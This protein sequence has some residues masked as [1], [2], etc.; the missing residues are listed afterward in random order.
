MIKAI[1][2]SLILMTS[3]TV[4]SADVVDRIVAIVNSEIILESDFRSLALKTKNPTMID[5][6]LLVKGDLGSLKS[7]RKAQ[8][9]YLINEKLMDAEVKRL[10]LT[11]TSERIQQEIKEMG[12]R[13]GLQA[14]DVL[15]AVKEQGIS[16]SD[17][18]DFLKTKIERQ[19]LVETEIVSKLRITDDDAL[20]EYLKK[21]PNNKNS[22]NE[23]SVAHIFF[24]PKKGTAEE[25]LARAKKVLAMLGSG[26]K[27]EELAEKFSEDP[28][29]TS[30]GY[31]GTFK[32]GEFLKEVEDSI[33]SLNAGEISSV[34]KSRMGFHI[35]KLISKKITTDSQFEKEKPRLISELM[36]S[37]FRRQLK[38]WLQSKRDEA[39]IRIN[40][41]K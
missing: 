15:N 7:D 8:M 3:L 1:L 34:V 11:V 25:A 33:Q 36:E 12:K 32:T 35:V 20:N 38:I 23:F 6:T 24:S 41:E 19:S 39:F 28:N 37:H 10:N 17:Y 29:F 31:L 4:Q 16:P 2:F 21:N 27:F 22:V 26:E 9:N 13:N 14:Q 40:G 30:G 5:E 18:Q